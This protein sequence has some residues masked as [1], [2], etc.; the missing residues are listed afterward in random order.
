MKKEQARERRL[1]EQQMIMEQTQRQ[2]G[3]AQD[4]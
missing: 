4:P 3:G 1:M 2:G